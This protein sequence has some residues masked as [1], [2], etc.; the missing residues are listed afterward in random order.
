MNTKKTYERASLAVISLD[1]KDVITTSGWTE[2]KDNGPIVMP[3]D[4]F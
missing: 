1:V 4:I 2:D 3:D